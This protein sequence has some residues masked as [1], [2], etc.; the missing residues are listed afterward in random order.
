MTL[1]T[2]HAPEA[3]TPDPERFVFVKDGFCWPAL[4]V[5]ELWLIFRRQWL[6]LILYIL[7]AVAFAFAAGRLAEPLPGFALV[8]L[9]FFF[10]LEANGLRRWTLERNRYRL[11]GV[12]EGRGI[13]DAEL[14]FFDGW[15][16][17]M[18]ATP[19]ADGSAPP[20]RAL[21]QPVPAEPATPAPW[22]PSVEAGEVVGLFPSPGRTP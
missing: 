6:V 22:T 10:A 1:Y 2:V 17:D 13:G 14:R 5:P 7:A 12:V 9:R 21:R 4:F 3:A 15:L 20:A 8:L 18:P 16:A 11:I 19:S